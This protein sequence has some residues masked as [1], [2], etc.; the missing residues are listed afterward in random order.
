MEQ[1]VEMSFERFSELLNSPDPRVGVATLTTLRKNGQPNLGQ[2]IFEYGLSNM[3]DDCM[4][5]A[6]QILAELRYPLE[7]C[8]E[9]DRDLFTTVIVTSN[10]GIILAAV[11]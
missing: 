9:T 6:L 1:Q 3:Y 4:A 2:L 7:G 11:R 10:E 5:V 8:S